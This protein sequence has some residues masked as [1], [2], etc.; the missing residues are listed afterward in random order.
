MSEREWRRAE[1]WLR[2]QRIRDLE[3][4]PLVASRIAG[5]LRTDRIEIGISLGLAAIIAAAVMVDAASARASDVEQAA[6]LGVGAIAATYALMN[7]VTSVMFWLRRRDDQ[8]IARRLRQ[9]VTRAEAATLTTVL[10]VGNLRSLAL[11]YGG[12][13][14]VGTASI[15]VATTTEDRQLAGV[16]VAG[17]ALFLASSGWLLADAV[18]R[19]AIA[20]DEPSLRAD[21]LLRR[22]DA[23]R[24]LMPYTGPLAAVAAVSSAPGS[25]L[26]WMFLG[27]SVAAIVIWGLLAAPA[28]LGRQPSGARA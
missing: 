21:E 28:V 10:G 6:A 9:R 27:Y 22:K 3:L 4:T 26:R 7:V 24:T 25:P 5:R 12:A 2:R 11:I 18:R 16:F 14:L 20:D 17:T 23:C 13:L 1:H 15:M 19:P 8:R